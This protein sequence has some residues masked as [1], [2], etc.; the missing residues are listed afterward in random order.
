MSV[1]RRYWEHFLV[2]IVPSINSSFKGWPEVKAAYR[3]FDNDNVSSDQILHP[4]YQASVRRIEKEEI[5]LCVQDTTI[6]NYSHRKQLVLVIYII[7]KIKDCYYILLL[8]LTRAGF[9]L[10]CL[11]IKALLEMNYRGRKQGA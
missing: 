11:I 8:L 10:A 5:I 6:L 9:V 7:P 3:F 1:L 2:S 4:H